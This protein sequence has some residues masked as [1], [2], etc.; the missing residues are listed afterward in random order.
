MN[1]NEVVRQLRL[2]RNVLV[3]IAGLLTVI[4]L[5]IVNDEIPAEADFA[6]LVMIII[7]GGLVA[8]AVFSDVKMRG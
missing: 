2:I 5:V 6:L 7:S 1:N 4:A 8:S 3:A